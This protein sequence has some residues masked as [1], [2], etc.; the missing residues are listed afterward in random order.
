MI[1]AFQNVFSFTQLNSLYLLV[2]QPSFLTAK[3]EL[4]FATAR[5]RVTGRLPDQTR[6]FG[7]YLPK[8]VIQPEATA[9]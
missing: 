2:V 9:S 4:Q 3:I 5:R 1:I 7:M 8:Y 6:W